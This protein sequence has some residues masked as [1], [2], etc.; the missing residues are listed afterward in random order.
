MYYPFPN[1]NH[2]HR[3]TYPNPKLNHIQTRTFKPSLTLKQAFEVVRSEE[4]VP[5]PKNALFFIVE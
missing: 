5:Y 3:P 2:L 1:P 4:N